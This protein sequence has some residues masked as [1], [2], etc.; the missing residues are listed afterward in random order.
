MPGQALRGY[1]EAPPQPAGR[2]AGLITWDLLQLR[3]RGG[4]GLP[5]PQHEPNIGFEWLEHAARD[6]VYS[7]VPY[8]HKLM[9]LAGQC[10]LAGF[11]KL[12]RISEVWL[13][14]KLW[15]RK[16]CRRRRAVPCPQRLPGLGD[17]ACWTGSACRVWFAFC[18]S[19]T[20]IKVAAHALLRCFTTANAKA[21]SLLRL[22]VRCHS[23]CTEG[24]AP[25]CGFQEEVEST[26][27]HHCAA[28]RSSQL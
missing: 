8:P 15:L 23:Q 18:F 4:V 10:T 19:R 9:K 5:I 13:L 17:Q 21:S 12:K 7:A 26:K 20:S 25:T 3:L 2:L 24:H 1:A 28:V 14:S 6:F 16:A 11:R 22:R 27:G